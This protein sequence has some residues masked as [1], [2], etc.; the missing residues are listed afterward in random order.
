MFSAI[1]SL[2]KKNT[3]IPKMFLNFLK[4]NFSKNEKKLTNILLQ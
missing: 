4:E 3:F 1:S 2:R